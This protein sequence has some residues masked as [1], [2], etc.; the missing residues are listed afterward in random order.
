MNEIK[1]IV[2][3]SD[4]F[5][6]SKKEKSAGCSVAAF[7]NDENKILHIKKYVNK[8]NSKLRKIF[9]SDETNNSAEYFALYTAL[10]VCKKLMQKYGNITYI[11]YMDSELIVNQINGIYSITK[12]HLL[13]MYN[14]CKLLEEELPYVVDIVWIKRIKL[15]EILGH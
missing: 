8:L 9:N 10:K 15:V 3:Y 6:K 5:M 7:E 13:K 11:I 12:P 1:E 2:I 4:G 14:I